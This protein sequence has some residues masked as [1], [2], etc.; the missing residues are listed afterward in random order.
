MERKK[1]KEVLYKKEEISSQKCELLQKK[2]ETTENYG[3]LQFGKITIFSKE[4]SKI[5]SVCSKM[6][7]SIIVSSD[8]LDSRTD[9]AISLSYNNFEE[10]KFLGK[11]KFGQVHLVKYAL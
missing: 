2:E 7:S 6:A 5:D 8:V 11:G 3:F 10:I 9:K 1:K 4:Q